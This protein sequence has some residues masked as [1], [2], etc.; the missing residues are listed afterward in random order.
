MFQKRQGL[1]KGHRSQPERV[2]GGQNQ[3]KLRKK[4]M[5]LDYSLKIK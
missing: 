4:I 1:S 3:E 5:F 2:P